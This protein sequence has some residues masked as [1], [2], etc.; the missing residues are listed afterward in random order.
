MQSRPEHLGS[1]FLGDYPG[2]VLPGRIVAHVLCVTAFEVGDPMPFLVDV[3]ANDPSR[4]TVGRRQ[5][6]N[7]L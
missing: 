4:Y 6:F 7:A 5:D 1:A 2:S 3:K